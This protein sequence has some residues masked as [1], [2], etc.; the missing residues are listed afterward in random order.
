MPRN[1]TT[2]V[3]K[4]IEVPKEIWEKCPGCQKIVL[5]KELLENFKLCP[6]CNHAFRMSAA[7][8]IAMF[9]DEGS[10]Q[11]FGGD[12]LPDDPIGFPGYTSQLEKSRTKSGASEAVTCGFGRIG[13][14]KVVFCALDFNFVGG[15]MGC[16]MGER[17]TLAFEKA[18]KARL[19]IIIVSS[20][21]GARMQEGILSLMQMAKTSAAAAIHHQARLPF[22]SVLADPTS[23][24]VTA[25]FAML[26]DFNIGEAGAFIG[27]AGP[28]VI[29]QTI[30]EK[31]PTGFQSASF[32]LEH[33]FL[34]AVVARKDMKPLVIKLLKLCTANRPPAATRARNGASQ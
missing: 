14:M 28:R 9:L 17:I 4:A 25:S 27:F 23:G 3:E 7:E 22:I 31:L 33:G 34:D 19:P 30:K 11:E 16:V 20:S 6:T 13:G 18:T 26:G 12:I 5:K 2:A 15:S 24:G 32:V 1:K 8:R 10:F 29:E 21:G